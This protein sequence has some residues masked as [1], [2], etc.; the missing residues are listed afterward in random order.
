[1]NI[2]HCKILQIVGPFQDDLRQL[3]GNYGPNVNARFASTPY[4]SLKALGKT[5]T[6]AT[7]CLDGH[8]CK[9]Y[10]AAD[11]QKAVKDANI[12]VICLGLGQFSL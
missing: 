10:S 1:M 2:Y 11:V 3:W 8:S 12:V 9:K 6:S 7:G 5:S 4:S